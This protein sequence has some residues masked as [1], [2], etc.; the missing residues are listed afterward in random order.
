MRCGARHSKLNVML[1]EEGIR[2]R[3]IKLPTIVTL[4]S[5]EEG[6]ELCRDIGM[7]L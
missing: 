2:E 4:N 1:L 3:V 6:G 5:F 7:K